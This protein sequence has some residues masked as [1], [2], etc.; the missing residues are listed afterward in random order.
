M[1]I[2][3]KPI[4]VK[5]EPA[6][7]L[8]LNGVSWDNYEKLL[9]V[10]DGHN[11]RMTYDRGD[12]ELMSPLPPHEI[13]KSFLRRILEEVAYKLRIPF[14]A[15][16]ST[17]FR[18][19]DR[20]RGLEPDEC[21]YFQSAK[22]VRTWQ[23]IDLTRDP[24]PDLALEIDIT[25]SSVDRMSVYAGLGIPEV[26]RFDGETLQS[27]HLGDDQTYHAVGSSSL[28]P[29]VPLDEILLLLQKAIGAANDVELIDLIREWVT[30]TVVPMKQEWDRSR[31]PSSE[32]N[33]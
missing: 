27:Y 15:L 18:R 31:T 23:R 2:V 10:L 13:F 6:Q 24:P 20:N 14:R 22:L 16:G 19:Q 12:L 5:A 32:R 26:W 17:T 4:P 21:F 11:V 29:F 25:S 8:V 9:E 7:R 3:E 1:S 33:T 30:Q 28:L